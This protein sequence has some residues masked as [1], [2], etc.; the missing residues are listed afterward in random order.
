MHAYSI[1][2]YVPTQLPTQPRWQGKFLDIA[3]AETSDSVKLVLTVGAVTRTN[4]HNLQQGQPGNEVISSFKLSRI[5]LPNFLVEFSPS[6]RPMFCRP[7]HFFSGYYIFLSGIKD[8]GK[9]GKNDCVRYELSK[10]DERWETWLVMHS[11]PDF[12]PMKSGWCSWLALFTR[13]RVAQI[14][15]GRRVARPSPMSRLS[16]FWTRLGPTNNSNN[17]LYFLQTVHMRSPWFL[18]IP[19]DHHGCLKLE[20]AIGCSGSHTAEANGGWENFMWCILC[21]IPIWFPAMLLWLVEL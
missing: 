16:S 21:A 10:C 13:Q 1:H 12:W 8:N 19:T 20:P 3:R 5:V 4:L 7:H 2:A 15:M 11:Y 14:A 17:F 18:T 6:P 9:M